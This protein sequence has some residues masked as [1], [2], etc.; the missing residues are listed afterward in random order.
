MSDDLEKRITQLEAEIIGLK[1]AV[2]RLMQTLPADP[3]TPFS[4]RPTFSSGLDA[5]DPK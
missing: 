3:R 1:T 5:S 4:S 2:R